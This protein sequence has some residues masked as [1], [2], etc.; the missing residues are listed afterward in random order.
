M[1]FRSLQTKRDGTI[2]VNGTLSIVNKEEPQ[3]ADVMIVSGKVIYDAFGRV[4][5][6]YYPT[7]E[8]LGAI[9]TFNSS[10]DAVDPTTM[11]YDV[12]DRNLTTTLPD[13]SIIKNEYGFGEDRDGVMQFATCTTDPMDN[14][15]TA[16]STVRGWQTATLMPDDI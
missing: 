2:L 9:A 12:L 11:T 14:S 8:A 5:E 6:T 7:T 3:F 4:T 10:V 16:Y 1:L 13:G 15:S